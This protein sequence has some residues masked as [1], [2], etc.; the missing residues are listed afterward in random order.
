VNKTR[1]TVE[2]LNKDLDK[3]AEV[4]ALYPLTQSGMVLRYS[5]ELSDYGFCEFRIA[6]EDPIFDT[7]GDII[8]PHKYHVR[9][10]RGN[11]TVWQG[12]IVD[13]PERSS[14]YFAVR[15][16]EY[17]F[18]LGKVLVKR[19]R[20]VGYGQTE[21]SGA[22]GLHYRVFSSGTMASAITNVITE[23]KTALGTGHVLNGL[24]LGTVENP[25][26]PKNFTRADGT[27][28]T[29]NWTFSDDVVLEFDYHSVLYVI[30]AFGIYSASD[31]TISNDL[32]FDFKKFIGKKNL[33][34]TFE[35]GNRGNI[36][37]YNL[38]RYGSRMANDIWGIAADPKGIILHS[39]KRDEASIN[40]YGLMQEPKAYGDVK[41]KNP[42]SARLSEEI[43]F[44]RTPEES[45]INLV[46]NEKAYPE[47]QYDIGD[48]VTVK[49]KDRTLDFKAS[50]RIVGITVSLHNTGRELTS[51]QT[52]RPR[53][54]DIEGLA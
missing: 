38:P 28:L 27:K 10:R 21:P 26:F 20:K 41:G 9:I 29:G 1:T 6:N 11:K 37:D 19:T 31:F 54:E 7:F 49:I 8:E 47:G 16:H 2:I 46:L 34:T 32:V 52:N 53:D 3:I 17:D 50:R 35:Y 5:T 36:T 13:N 48:L 14:R 43:G 12:A 40:T 45:P 42:L 39:N 30:K 44:L 33:S 18:Y 25:P 24:T 15:A 23:V 4:R 51:I 22:I